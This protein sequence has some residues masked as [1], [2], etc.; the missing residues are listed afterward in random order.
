[1]R[2]APRA[3]PLPQNTSIPPHPPRSHAPVT[4]FLLSV[5]R[6]A[7]LDMVLAALSCLA[8]DP[9]GNPSRHCTTQLAAPSAL[10]IDRHDSPR[11][12]SW[13]RGTT[14]LVVRQTRVIPANKRQTTAPNS[15]TGNTAPLVQPD[16]NSQNAPLTEDSWNMAPY[17][18]VYGRWVASAACSN[19]VSS[20]QFFPILS[21]PHSVTL[22]KFLP[23]RM[24]SE[25][26]S[27]KLASSAVAAIQ[28]QKLRG[29]PRK[30]AYYTELASSLQKYLMT[31]YYVASISPAT[32]SSNRHLSPN[33]KGS[34]HM[35][36]TTGAS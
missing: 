13:P 21:N 3:G 36:P 26:P 28:S 4:I 33:P 27:F 16:Y 2:P 31:T 23:P 25:S 5:P 22:R 20:T 19:L 6:F 1:M 8:T 9:L 15:P 30:L 17:R 14:G 32:F 29:C 35:H 34:Q 7:C 12:R 11:L 24:V 18:L 10:R